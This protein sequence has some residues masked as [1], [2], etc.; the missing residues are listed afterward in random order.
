MAKMIESYHGNEG[1]PNIAFQTMN[2]FAYVSMSINAYQ[3]I[4][5]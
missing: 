1:D 3:N 4:T 5:S 2:Y